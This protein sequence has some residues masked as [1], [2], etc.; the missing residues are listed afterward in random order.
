MLFFTGMKGGA[1]IFSQNALSYRSPAVLIYSSVPFIW[2]IFQ[3]FNCFPSNI[4]QRDLLAVTT[5]ENKI[6][7]ADQ[8]SVDGFYYTSRL[9]VEAA[10]KS[11]QFTQLGV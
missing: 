9:K 4:K 1:I 11:L 8:K 5:P 6:N 10:Q 3:Q 7:L 2:V